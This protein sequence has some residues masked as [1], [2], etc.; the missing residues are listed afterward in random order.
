MGQVAYKLELPSAAKIH[1]I[2]HVSYLKKHMGKMLTQFQLPL[3]DNDEVLAK[4]PIAVLDRRMVKRRGRAVT[5]VLVHWSNYFLE[6]TTWECLYDLKQ[7]FLSFDSWRHGSFEGRGIVMRWLFELVICIFLSCYFHLCYF[8]F[9]C[10]TLATSSN[11]I[12]IVREGI[13]V[14]LIYGTTW[15]EW[16]K[17]YSTHYLPSLIF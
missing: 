8:H 11:S 6:D 13:I 5:E 12:K 16:T 4:E 10:V 2:F 1:P 9:V 17:K 3:L 15:N 7:Q 14:F